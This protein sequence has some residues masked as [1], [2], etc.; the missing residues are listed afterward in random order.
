[1][2]IVLMRVDNR[3]IH[4]QILEG[5]LPWLEADQLII[6]S[7]EIAGDTSQRRILETALTYP[8][9][10]IIDTVERVINLLLQDETVDVKRAV[11]VSHPIDALRIK[12]AGV[13]FDRLILGNLG[14]RSEPLPLSNRVMVGPAGRRALKEI[15]VEG[16][17]VSI[18][19]VPT[20]EPVDLTKICSSF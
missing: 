6:A 11:I 17:T 16:V 8:I 10:L 20:D 3:F 2:P 1:M 9:G 7:D 12:R 13:S 5:W 14:A 4:G 19:G 15:I 18:Q